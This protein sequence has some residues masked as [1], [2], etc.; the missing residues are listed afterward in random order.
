VPEHVWRP[1]SARTRWGSAEAPPDP[2]VAMRG[3][4]LRGR[5]GEIEE[6]RG[7]EGGKGAEGRRERG[8]NEGK[9][10]T[11]HFGV[12]FT[13]LGKRLGFMSG[14]TLPVAVARRRHRKPTPNHAESFCASPHYVTLGLLLCVTQT[15]VC[16]LYNVCSFS[17]SLQSA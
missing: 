3:L 7:G 12:K 8:G 5:G 14:L 17:Q 10:W 11:S 13:P 9:E 6:G 1:G 16:L 15:A 2:L 4:L